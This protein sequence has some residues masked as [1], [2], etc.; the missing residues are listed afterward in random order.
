MDNLT[1]KVSSFL[2]SGIQQIWSQMLNTILA[3]FTKCF[4]I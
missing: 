4:L 1:F 2:D 3:I